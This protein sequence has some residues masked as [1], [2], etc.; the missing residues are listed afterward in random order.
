MDI[1]ELMLISI[2]CLILVAVA[3]SAPADLPMKA[4]ADVVR[5][6]KDK[7][8]PALSEQM[9]G[10]KDD[11]IPVIVTLEGE[12]RPD[13]DGLDA[14]P[15]RDDRSGNSAMGFLVGPKQLDPGGC[16]RL[17]ISLECW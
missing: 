6:D 5:L 14:L 3:L 8:D 10:S 7:I 17:A 4:A 15:L 2:A 1:R 16:A 13:L 9:Y 11:R 12:N